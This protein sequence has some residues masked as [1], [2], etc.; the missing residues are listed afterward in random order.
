MDLLLRERQRLA[1]FDLQDDQDQ[2]G[3]VK[4]GRNRLCGDS[5]R[6]YLGRA[7]RVPVSRAGPKGGAAGGNSGPCAQKS[8]AAVVALEAR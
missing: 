3:R 5:S 7:V 1:E 4:D 6:V 2:M 8:A